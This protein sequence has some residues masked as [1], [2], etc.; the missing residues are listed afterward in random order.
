MLLLII[1]ALLVMSCKDVVVYYPIP[2]TSSVEFIITTSGGS[3]EENLPVHTDEIFADLQKKLA[4]FG[5]TLSDVDRIRLEG[6]AY[7]ITKISNASARISGVVDLSYDSSPFAT[8]MSLNQLLLGDI[9]GVPQ[10]NALSKEG[11][12]LLNQGLDDLSNGIVGVMTVKSEGSLAPGTTGQ[13]TF[14]MLVEFTITSVVT[15]KQTVFSP[16]G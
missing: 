13:V 2:L 1:S 10:K 16:L 14:T 7:T 5:L 4:E 15:K 12:T 11:V 3:Y 9:E 6:A 8:V